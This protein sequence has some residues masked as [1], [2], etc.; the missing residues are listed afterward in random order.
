MGYRLAA[1][2]VVLLHVLFVV[3]VVAGGLL[4][5]RWRWIPF[6][7]LPAAA[8]GALIEFTHGVCPLTP[9]EQ[10]L[11]R[12]AAEPG[13]TG[14]FIEHYVVRILYPPGLTAEMQ[15]VLGTAVLLVNAAA[16]S[17]VLRSW[18][19]RRRTEPR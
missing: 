5:L 16:Y 7:H 2:G 1:D 8:W 15:V 14:G 19:R 9:L 11:R 10:H 18:R 12:L 3:F 4:A 13:Y 6:L 17:L